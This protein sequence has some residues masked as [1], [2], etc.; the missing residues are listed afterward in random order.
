[1]TTAQPIRRIAAAIDGSPHSRAALDTAA[2]I[3]ARR[4]ATLVG[5]VVEYSALP[6]MFDETDKL[7]GTQKQQ[8]EVLLQRAA[9]KHGLD[10]ELTVMRGAVAEEIMRS[11]NDA[12]LLVLGRSGRAPSCCKGLGSSARRVIH[13]AATPVM[14]T[15][16]GA[17]AAEESLLVLCD[18]PNASKRAFELTLAIRS[19]ESTLHLL[20]T[21]PAPDAV[22][23]CRNELEQTLDD[24]SIETGFYHLPFTDGKQLASF[25]RMIDSGLLVI[26]EG[27]HLPDESIATLIE[28]IDDAVLVAR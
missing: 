10:C 5:I 16:P 7:T 28:Q 23:R 9:G 19:P 27:I 26:G 14:L 3:A 22:E 4:K 12:D 25:I 17:T 2:R 13:E 8:A 11:A 15:R 18:G 1:M 24:K 20:V 6:E 21:D